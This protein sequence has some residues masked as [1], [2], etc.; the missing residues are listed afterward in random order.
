MKRFFVGVGLLGLVLGCGVLGF[1]GKKMEVLAQSMAHCPAILAGYGG[2]NGD[3]DQNQDGKVNAL[4]CLSALFPNPTATATPSPTPETTAQL[5]KRL[6]TSITSLNSQLL[7]SQPLS[8]SQL[9]SIATQR[10]TQ[11]LTLAAISPDDAYKLLFTDGQGV[12]VLAKSTDTTYQAGIESPITATGT[13]GILISDDFV[14]NQATVSYS[15]ATQANPKTNYRLFASSGLPSHSG[16]VLQVTGMN[17]GNSIIIKSPSSTSVPSEGNPMVK[18]IQASLVAQTIGTRKLLVLPVTATDHNTIPSRALKSNLESYVNTNNQYYLENSYGKF[19]WQ[20]TIQDYKQMNKPKPT[21]CIETG[22]VL[23]PNFQEYAKAALA[24]HDQD[25]NYQN[26]DHSSIVIVFPFERPAGCGQGFTAQEM[27]WVTGDGTVTAALTF[28]FLQSTSSSYI[29]TFTHELG[30]SIGLWHGDGLCGASQLSPDLP[31]TCAVAYGHHFYN[32]GNPD[33]VGGSA[34]QP[35]GHFSAAR[36][37]ELGWLPPDGQIIISPTTKGVYTIGPNS[38]N[39]ASTPNTPLRSVLIDFK[40]LISE[41]NWKYAIEYRQPVGYDKQLTAAASYNGALIELLTN[42]F[43]GTSNTFDFDTSPSTDLYDPML[44]PGQSMTT[45]N[46]FTYDPVTITTCSADSNG[47][48]VA[49]NQDCPLA[50]GSPAAA[51]NG[52]IYALNNGRMEVYNPATQTWTVKSSPPTPLSPGGS[53]DLVANR[54]FYYR[55]NGSGNDGL[56]SYGPDD[57][58]WIKYAG[59]GDLQDGHGSGYINNKLFFLGSMQLATA[60]TGTFYSVGH[61]PKFP[62]NWG[63][64][65]PSSRVNRTSAMSIVANNRVCLFGGI[66]KNSPTNQVIPEVDCYDPNLDPVFVGGSSQPWT[67]G[68]TSLPPGR[69]GGSAVIKGNLVYVFGGANTSGAAITAAST[70]L[71]SRVD[72]YN[73]TTNTWTTVPEWA[74]PRIGHTAVLIGNTVYNVGGTL[75]GG[76]TPVKRVDPYVLPVPQLKISG[77]WRLH[78]TAA[79]SQQYQGVKVKAVRTGGASYETLTGPNGTIEFYDLPAGTYTVSSEYFTFST[80]SSNQFEYESASVPVTVGATTTPVTLELFDTTIPCS[81]YCQVLGATGPTC[82]ATGVGSTVKATQGSTTPVSCATNSPTT[83][84]CG[85]SGNLPSVQVITNSAS[86]QSCQEKCQAVGK[87]FVANGTEVTG[88]DGQVWA[89]NSRTNQ[90]AQVAVSALYSKMTSVNQSCQ[91]NPALWT[92]CRCA[93]LSE[94]NGIGGNQEVR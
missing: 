42:K 86:S 48:T 1:R 94:V 31:G 65:T 20:N 13:V 79:S 9:I 84:W 93:S 6:V 57:D 30:H 90:C 21:V 88:T 82:T 51:Y 7:S 52:Q 77:Q 24:A 15:L 2:A 16:A 78:Q 43:W 53:A 74:N 28:M 61:D 5:M 54:I 17:L 32:M 49:I 66:K 36:K 45:Y 44:M 89:F 76:V 87:V 25:I 81:S 11:L 8:S 56:I 60:T 50:S 71:V 26:Y 47:L 35:A 75:A 40:Y 85:C 37:A 72:V 10:Q 62:T 12:S 23:N 92:N 46:G 67:M 18:T 59:S 83:P 29:F 38:V 68:I 58:S 14:N 27:T 63:S 33:G 73:L 34:P 3:L 91:G 19:Q 69:I 70:P 4:D 64:I 55:V 22:G 80:Q 41:Q 39:P